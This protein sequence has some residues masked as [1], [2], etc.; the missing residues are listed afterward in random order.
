MAAEHPSASPWDVKHL[1]GGLIDVEFT[2]Q[3]LQLLHARAR[4]DIL[5]TNTAAALDKLAAAGF[6]P[7]ADAENLRRALELW[8]ALQAVLRL[9]LDPVA[10]ANP[11]A[12]QTTRP[13]RGAGGEDGAAF[14]ESLKR[15]LARIGGTADFAKLETRMGELARAAADVFHRAIEVPASS[16]T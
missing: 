8:Q 13:D 10:A 7:P 1:R 4:P 11:A 16:P 3:C 5:D 6:L 14:P 12:Q 2:V 9:T 15:R